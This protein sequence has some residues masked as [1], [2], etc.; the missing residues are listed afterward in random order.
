MKKLLS[1]LL[2]LLLLA[3]PVFAQSPLVNDGEG[4]LTSG[5]AAELEQLYGE[6]ARDYGFTPILVTTDSF[7]GYDAETY[8]GAYYDTHGYPYDGILLLVSLSEGQ[9]YILTNGICA[10]V[11]SDW[12]AESIGEDVVSYLR[13]GDYYGAFAAFPELAARYFSGSS[14]SIGIIGGADG[15]TAVFVTTER[16]FGKTIGISMAVGILIA[17]IVVGIM[18]YKMK[19]VRPQNSAGDYIRPGSMHLTQSRDIFLYSH[20]HRTPKPKNNSSGGGH[21]G[22]S[23]GGAGGRI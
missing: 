5:E 4:L 17:L 21:S 14:M 11:I 1:L 20:V 23:R 15:P 10:D 7:Q 3:V 16:N 22:G 6:Y 9:W 8:A 19:S 2:V 18:A 12:D 13:E